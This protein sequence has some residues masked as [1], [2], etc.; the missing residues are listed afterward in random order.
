MVDFARELPRHWYR[1][2]RASLRL[3]TVGAILLACSFAAWWLMLLP[4]SADVRPVIEF[5]FDRWVLAGGLLSMA[6]G[7]LLWARVWITARRVVPILSLVV[8]VALIALTGY[9]EVHTPTSSTPPIL[10]AVEGLASVLLLLGGLRGSR[11]AFGPLLR[12][13]GIERDAG[14]MSGLLR[15]TTYLALAVG[16]L[17]PFTP[18]LFGDETPHAC[19]LRIAA[20][21]ALAFTPP[22]LALAVCATLLLHSLRQRERHATTCLR[23]GYARPAGSTCPECGDK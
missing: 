11:R 6:F 10:H 4:S 23:C 13:F 5:L 8:G 16:M 18:R 1:T 14:R 12:I 21:S 19:S 15:R 20:T 17:L 22:L 2:T 9:R 3:F 7:V